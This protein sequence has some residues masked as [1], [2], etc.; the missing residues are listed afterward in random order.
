MNTL[1][2]R[3]IQLLATL[4][5]KATIRGIFM[6]FTAIVWLHAEFNNQK[7]ELIY[8]RSF[9]LYPAALAG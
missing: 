4:E 7:A 9:I 5:A 3:Y 1:I 8:F 6:S 2:Y